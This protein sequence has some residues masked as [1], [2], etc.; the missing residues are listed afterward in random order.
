MRLRH[1]LDGG[2]SCRTAREGGGYHGGV[3]GV[4]ARAGYERSPV[5]PFIYVTL[6][7]SSIVL[8]GR[9]CEYDFHA[10]T[11]GMK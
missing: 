6:H 8:N 1:S 9:Y 4:Y 10:E 3:Q 2:Q 7:I 11:K 5:S